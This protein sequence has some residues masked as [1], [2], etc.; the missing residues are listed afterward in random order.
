MLRSELVVRY[1]DLIDGRQKG[2]GHCFIHQALAIRKSFLPVAIA[3]IADYDKRR[4]EERMGIAGNDFSGSFF[5][6]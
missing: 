2:G 3:G 6:Y 1:D 4:P 5:F